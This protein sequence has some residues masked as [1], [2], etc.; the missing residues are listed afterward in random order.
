MQLPQRLSITVSDSLR[1]SLFFLTSLDNDTEIRKGDYVLFTLSDRP[2][3]QKVLVE[4][5][6]NEPEAARFLQNRQLYFIKEVVC[7][8]GDWFRNDGLDFYCNSDHPGRAKPL[9]LNNSPLHHFA[10]N[11]TVPKGCLA[12]FGHSYDSFDSRYFGFITRKEVRSTA[13]PV[14]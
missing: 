13:W 2:L 5:W 10:F 9:S 8:Q 6:K 3:V 11:G 4:S 1:Y 12:V 14:W 7:T